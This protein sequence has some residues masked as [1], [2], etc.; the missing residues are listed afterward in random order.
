MKEYP[1]V[2][3][4]MTA[5]N[6]EKYIAEAIESVLESTLTDFEL[7]IVDD[8][9]RDNTVSIAKSFAGR[10]PRIKVFCNDKNL[11][12]Y[13][14]RN[15][16]ASY[17]KGKY[18]KYVDSDDKIFPCCL[19]KMV[20]G[21]ETFPEAEWGVVASENLRFESRFP[22][23]L[24]PNEIFLISNAGLISLSR[25]PLSLIIKRSCF[26]RENGFLPVRQWSDAEFCRR[27]ALN[28]S[29]VV[30]E[31][32]LVWYRT[33]ED[34]ENAVNSRNKIFEVECT[35]TCI[36]LIKNNGKK[37]EKENRMKA[38]SIQRKKQLNVFAGLIKS[39]RFQYA[40]ELLIVLIKSNPK[41]YYERR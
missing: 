28:H 35:S 7:I 37:V 23:L 39:F 19:T 32:N 4:L 25:S 8:G 40:L 11:G 14:N 34:Q 2:S 22:F 29:L 38:I 13:P 1:L 31:N 33:H 26:E 41:V 24:H 18:I 36:Y 21:M 9:S 17:A 15:K 6:R 27:L 16:A 12:D 5:Y 3:I 10:D 20:K 30:V